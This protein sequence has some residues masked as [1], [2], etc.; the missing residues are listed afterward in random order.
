MK[1]ACV[2]E[3]ASF[4]ICQQH[5]ISVMTIFETYIIILYF[6]LSVFVVNLQQFNK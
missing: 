4:T 6:L 2:L 3:I 5:L 1:H